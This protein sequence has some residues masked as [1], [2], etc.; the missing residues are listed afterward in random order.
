VF[1]RPDRDVRALS[2]FRRFRSFAKVSIALATAGYVNLSWRRHR[3]QAT[4]HNLPGRLTVTLTSYPPRYPTLALT[5]KS[6]LAQSLRPDRLYL[7]IAEADLASLP[8][9]VTRLQ[10]DGLAIHVCEDLRSYKKIIPALASGN[11]DFLVTADD[12]IYYPRHWLRD[13]VGAYRADHKEVICYR[14]HRIRLDAQ[15]MPMPYLQWQGE[16]AAGEDTRLLFPTSGGGALYAPGIFHADVTR[17]EIFR[18]VCPTADDVW[19]YW[20]A[21][22]NGARFRRVGPRWRMI[23]WANSQRVAL[24]DINYIANDQQIAN[25]VALYGFPRACDR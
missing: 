25:M 9:N 19:L 22:L 2:A 24:Q 6:L 14:A 7:W 10:T 15:G 8:E 11:D 4:S 17:A 1:L 23:E 13:I 12:D 21:A 5:L 16:V 18:D 20:M 3:S